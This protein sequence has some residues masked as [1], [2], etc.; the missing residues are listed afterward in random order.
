M[1]RLSDLQRLLHRPQVFCRLHAEHIL[2]RQAEIELCQL[3]TRPP[4]LC[5]LNQAQ[6]AGDRLS[7]GSG[8]EPQAIQ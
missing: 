2:V 1:R 6:E 8:F 4:G 5:Q 3:R 7:I